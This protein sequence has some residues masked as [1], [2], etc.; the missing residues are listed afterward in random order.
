MLWGEVLVQLLD[1][2][3]TQSLPSSLRLVWRLSFCAE[4]HTTKSKRTAIS[5]LCRL[6]ALAMKGVWSEIGNMSVGWFV[7]F[8]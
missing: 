6:K 1:A 8:M 3:C 2:T 5:M 7:T 4:F